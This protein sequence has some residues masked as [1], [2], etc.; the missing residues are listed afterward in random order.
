MPNFVGR[1]PRSSTCRWC[2]GGGSTVR[3]RP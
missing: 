3:R 2:R 1:P